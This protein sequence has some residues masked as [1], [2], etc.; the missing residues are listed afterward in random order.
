[1]EQEKRVYLENEEEFFA[2]L[3]EVERESRFQETERYIQH[4]VTSVYRHSLAVAFYSCYLAERFQL[5]VRRK[6]MIRGALLHDYFLYDW[7]EKS[8]DHRFHGFTHPGRA[9][10][11]AARDFDLTQVEKDIIQKHMFPL[12]PIPPAHLE[13]VL[14]C[15]ADKVCSTY[16]TVHRRRLE[17]FLYR[18]S[19]VRS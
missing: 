16:E 17:W 11:N 9:L 8:D 5:R 13:S 10:R 6:E 12:T 3:E 4:G 1:M 18:L 14:V 7:H 19:L 15:I 2:I